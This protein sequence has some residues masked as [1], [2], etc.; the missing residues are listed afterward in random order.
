MTK[1]QVRYGV[2]VK[3]SDSDDEIN[4]NLIPDPHAGDS[5]EKNE[6]FQIISF[7]FF[8]KRVVKF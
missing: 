5:F 2:G 1:G 8:K 4:H 3:R 7:F 6:K